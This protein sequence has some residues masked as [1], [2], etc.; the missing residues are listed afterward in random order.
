MVKEHNQ[1]SLMFSGGIDSMYCALKLASKYESVHLLNYSNGYGHMFLN[2]SKKRYLSLIKG[3]KNEEKYVFSY[4]SIKKLF[5]K[6]LIDTLD[7]DMEKYSSAFIWCM[8]CKLSM[9]AETIAYD[10][11]NGIKRSTDGSSYETREMVEQSPF[12]ISLIKKMYSKYGIDFSPESY[13][14]SRAE[15][16]AYLKQN[17]ISTGI[18]I[19]DRNIGIQPK[20]IPGELYYSPKIILGMEPFHQE[21]EIYKFYKD[22]E[23]ILLEHI[24]TKVSKLGIMNKTHIGN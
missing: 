23:S 6:V 7:K 19:L 11:I 17:G 10:I 4:A 8:G 3:G 14:I 13:K 5:N 24:E 2:E 1:V 22:K 18:K 12:S 21:K 9:H 15:K 16:L 20:C